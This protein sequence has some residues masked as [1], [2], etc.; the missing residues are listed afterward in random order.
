MAAIAFVHQNITIA[1]VC[2]SFSVLLGA[3]E[4]RLG[5]GRELST[6]AVPVLNLATALLAATVG[7]LA[8]RLSLRLVMVAGAAFSVAGFALLA[9]SA[10]YPL[11]LIA[12]G[13]LLGPGMAIG[14]VLPPTLVTRWYVVNRGRA[15]GIV[16]TPVVIA[17]MPLATTWMLQ[18][19]GLPL[20]YAMLAA[21]SAVS[22]VANLF[23]IDRPPGTAAA[24]APVDAHGAHGPATAGAITMAQL[25]R[26]A[27]FWALTLAFMAS[28]AGSIVLTAHMA[29]M[30]RTWGYSATL[31]ATLLSIQSFAGI[32]GTVVFGWV[33]DRLG[34]ARAL[35]L[36]VFDAAL[37]WL[38]LLLHLPFA[39]TAAVIALAGLHGAGAVPVLSVALSESFGRESFSRA[40]GLANLVNLPVS[41]ACVPA[42][43]MIY[44]RSGSYAGAILVQAAFLLLASLLVMA[45]RGRLPSAAKK[46]YRGVL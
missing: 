16:T 36:V 8:A 23:I 34:G 17:A 12:F 13:L 39:A 18:A 41:V 37:L 15:L 42:A 14:V 5:V 1:C 27:R 29:P 2:G 20:T 7:A 10:S 25:L 30:A 4:T 9:L 3:V 40:F 24:A 38:L 33:A 35:A 26:S 45:A 11:Y 46:P 43:A 6:L 21:F 32:A 31:A 44:A 28:A 19:H 22:L